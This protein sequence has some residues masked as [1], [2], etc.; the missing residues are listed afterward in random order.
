V[1]VFLDRVG[2]TVF[3]Q[4]H[5]VKSLHSI[6]MDAICLGDVETLAKHD[7]DR[8]TSQ[9]ICDIVREKAAQIGVS[10]LVTYFHKA[11]EKG[12]SNI[13][14]LIVRKQN[15]IYFASRS[16]LE[17]LELLTALESPVV[18]MPSQIVHNILAGKTGGVRTLMDEH[19]DSKMMERLSNT[20][21]KTAAAELFKLLDGVCATTPM[22][23]YYD[24][25]KDEKLT[26]V[27]KG[28]RKY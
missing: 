21:S 10:N 23:D 12:W 9:I 7:F 11:K 22:K 15:R 26:I 13:I 27:V 6:V 1:E 16:E 28:L 2:N 17:G 5:G 19:L 14:N 8:E 18:D 20:E 4:K 25:T 24:A 3:K